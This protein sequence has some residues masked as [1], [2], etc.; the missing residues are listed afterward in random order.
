M[1]N[2]IAVIGFSNWFMSEVISPKLSTI[3]QPGYEMGTEAFLLLKEE[4][5]S[6]KNN[7]NRIS[8]SVV[9]PTKL[10]VRESTLK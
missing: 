2:Q 7:E 9:L 6:L 3:E 8:K 5:N 1:P 4:I 10:I